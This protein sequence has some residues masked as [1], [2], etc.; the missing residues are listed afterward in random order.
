MSRKNASR[1]TVYDATRFCSIDELEAMGVGDLRDELDRLLHG[2]REDASNNV[3]SK[4]I[5]AWEEQISWVLRESQ[6]RRCGT[7]GNYNT[8]YGVEFANVVR[9]ATANI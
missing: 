4:V 5:Q 1:S 8:L 7:Y 9:N 3:G 2:M 6:T